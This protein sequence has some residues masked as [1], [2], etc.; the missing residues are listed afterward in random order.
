VNCCL[1]LERVST[2]LS[3]EGQA[4]VYLRHSATLLG[5]T[6][7]DSGGILFP[8]EAIRGVEECISW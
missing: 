5:A 6:G 1:Y 8:S 2:M 4:S 7:D 3:P